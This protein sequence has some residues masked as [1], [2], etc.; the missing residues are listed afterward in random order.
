MN[1]KHVELF[2]HIM[3]FGTLT[4]AAQIMAVSQPAASKMLSQLEYSTG[5]SLFE[6]TKGRLKPTREGE[7]FFAEVQRTW[8]GIERL[9]RASKDISRMRYGHLNLGV[10]PALATT[11]MPAL[12]TH[13]RRK[14]THTTL[15]VHSRSSERIT[16][17]AIAGQID[18]GLVNAA[19]THPNVECR[20][21]A[22]IPGVCILPEGHPLTALSEIRPRDFHGQDY[23]SLGTFDRGVVIDKIFEEA[24]VVPDIAIEAPVANMACALVAS[25]AGIGVVDEMNAQSFVGRGLAVRPL[26]PPVS[27][28]IWHIRSVN[29]SRS[30]AVE[31]LTHEVEEEFERRGY[32][33]AFA[34]CK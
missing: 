1:M 21:V 3:H 11:L 24:G 25:G 7:L 33:V 6:R 13:F 27:F 22:R 5:I 18:V 17:W 32:R 15:S 31:A 12:I 10:L 2:R 19:T 14:N 34:Q 28:P 9:K 16:E 29:L 4:Q 30:V 26:T 20:L 23:V 8:Q